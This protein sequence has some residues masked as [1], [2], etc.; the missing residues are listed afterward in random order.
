MF[1]L[2]STQATGKDDAILKHDVSLPPYDAPGHKG[3]SGGVSCNA[4][5]YRAHQKNNIEGSHCWRVAHLLRNKYITSSS[6]Q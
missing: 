6:N 2:H 1:F 3:S 5:C 4:A